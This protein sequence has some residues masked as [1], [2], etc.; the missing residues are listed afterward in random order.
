A[1]RESTGQ[2]TGLGGGGDLS[3]GWHGGADLPVHGAE[4]SEAG[5]DRG[6]DGA[7]T[8]GGGAVRERLGQPPGGDPQGE[9][10]SV[11]DPRPR[12]G[13]RDLTVGTDRQD[14]ACG[15]DDRVLPGLIGPPGAAAA[16]PATSEGCWSSDAR[17]APQSVVG[18]LV[19]RA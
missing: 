12:P 9:S 10:G 14:G 1:G 17:G 3:G 5:D 11:R 13:A 2:R 8:R 7:S 6:G 4:R 15:I 18:F 19:T 16:S